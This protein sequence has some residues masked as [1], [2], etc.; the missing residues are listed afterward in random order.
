VPGTFLGETIQDG[1]ATL[2]RM[3]REVNR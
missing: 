3:L 2:D 1:L